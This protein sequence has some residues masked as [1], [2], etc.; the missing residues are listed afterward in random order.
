VTAAFWAATGSAA[1]WAALAAAVGAA[2]GAIAGAAVGSGAVQ[3]AW[4][5]AVGAFLIPAIALALLNLVV[6]LA[7]AAG[8]R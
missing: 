1:W 7:L 5:G 4:A 2:A 3:K 6:I 8:G